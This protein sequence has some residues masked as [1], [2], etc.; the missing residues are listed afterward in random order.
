MVEEI[1]SALPDSPDEVTNP[2]ALIEDIRKGIREMKKQ[3][4]ERSLPRIAALNR[5]LQAQ[6]I[7]KEFGIII[8]PEEVSRFRSLESLG[9]F[10]VHRW[11]CRQPCPAKLLGWCDAPKKSCIFCA[12]TGC[13]EW[14]RDHA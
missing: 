13:A 7:E 4:V 14:D 3:Q 5:R 8:E 1:L 10:V 2:H 12:N 6:E 9:E 11:M